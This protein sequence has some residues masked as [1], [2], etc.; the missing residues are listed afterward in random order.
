MAE[1]G[2]RDKARII[3]ITV[4]ALLVLD[5][6]AVWLMSNWNLGVLL[7]TIFGVPLLVY[8]IFKKPIDK[9]TARGAGWVVK[10]VLAVFY[11]AVAGIMAV[12][13]AVAFSAAAVGPD[14]GAD[15]VIVLGAGIKG[16]EVSS[17]L[18]KRLDTAAVYFAD[19]PGALIVVSG[20][21]GSGERV[22]E[23]YAMKK[24]L[25]EEKGIPEEKIIEEDRSTSTRENFAFS[26]ELLDGIFGG[27]YRVVYVTN[28][29]HIFRSGITARRAGLDAQGL[30]APTPKYIIPNSYMRESLA[31]LYTFVF[32]A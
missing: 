8:G 26:K 32:G 28:D 5:S 7:P 19:N 10:R 21:Y 14:S 24:Y 11:F 17:A 12:L 29:F 2:K 4:G 15:A 31:L 22:S 13:S 18:R 23:A 1:K 25:V 20:G 9:K 30:A 27:G 3:L 6:I 16:D